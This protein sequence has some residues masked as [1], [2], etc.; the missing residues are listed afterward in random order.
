MESSE[1]GSGPRPE[2]VID[3]PVATT[4]APPVGVM[5]LRP[6]EN[7]LLMRGGATRLSTGMPSGPA[8][9]TPNGAHAGAVWKCSCGI[10]KLPSG[11]SHLTTTRS[12]D[13]CER[14]NLALGSG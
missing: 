11:L 13:S 12:N 3:A 1:A 6:S 10:T 7:V 2:F 5:L 8:Q 4:H 9:P 14:K